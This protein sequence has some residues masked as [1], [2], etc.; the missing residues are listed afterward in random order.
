MVCQS[1]AML[2]V[3]SGLLSGGAL[4]CVKCTL[5][6]PKGWRAH[7]AASQ[8]E[9]GVCCNT[10]LHMGVVVVDTACL[11]SCATGHTVHVAS[12]SMGDR[13]GSGCLAAL[14]A[15]L[16]PHGHRACERQLQWHLARPILP[17]VPRRPS[18][19]EHWGLRH[20]GCCRDRTVSALIICA[21]VSPSSANE[22]PSPS[23]LVT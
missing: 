1:L 2:L 9:R 16:A 13:S 15:G 22:R 7:L 3:A 19:R 17:L 10:G 8:S 12:F 14:F 6:V 4:A 11:T 18:A 23:G 21:W 20:C 5:R